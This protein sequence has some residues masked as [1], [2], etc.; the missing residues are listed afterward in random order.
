VNLRTELFGA[1]V[2]NPGMQATD[3]CGFGLEA[4][5]RQ[6]PPWIRADVRK[7]REATTSPASA[8]WGA[9]W[10]RWTMPGP[11]LPSWK[12]GRHRSP[13]PAGIPSSP[14][15]RGKRVFQD[16]NLHDIPNTVAALAAL[17]AEVA[18]AGVP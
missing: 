3:T 4:M 1:I 16:L 14:P 11:G 8:G 9:A 13:C 2:Q 18:A 10:I 7:A 17:R 5:R 6:K 12:S 15:R